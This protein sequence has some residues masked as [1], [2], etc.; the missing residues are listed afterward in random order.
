ML[1]RIRCDLRKHPISTS[2]E[3]DTT[4]KITFEGGSYQPSLSTVSGSKLWLIG[5]YIRSNVM[6]EDV[7]KTGVP[8]LSIYRGNTIKTLLYN[9]QFPIKIATTWRYITH[10][11]FSP[12]FRIQ[13]LR[14]CWGFP[15]GQ[16]WSS[17]GI[18]SKTHQQLSLKTDTL[19]GPTPCC[20]WSPGSS[21]EWRR[22]WCTWGILGNLGGIRIAH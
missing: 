18:R 1:F 5:T 19:I 8:W 22:W 6:F 7:G 17:K 21:M 13:T 10:W 2:C 16:V 4:G 14:F 9:H 11:W 3:T 12:C 15:S 20:R